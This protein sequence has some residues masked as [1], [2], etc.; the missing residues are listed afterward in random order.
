MAKEEAQALT[1]ED[2]LLVDF[3]D[4]IMERVSRQ[5]SFSKE[6]IMSAKKIW[7]AR[8]ADNAP[9]PEVAIQDKTDKLPDYY[10]KG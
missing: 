7:D 5:M 10:V 1:L 9:L 6:L 2:K 4:T 3:Y 8:R